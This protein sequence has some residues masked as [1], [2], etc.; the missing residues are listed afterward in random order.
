MNAIRTALFA[1]AVLATTLLTAQAEPQPGETFQEF[2]Y[3][4]RFIELD[5]ANT[6][7]NL[8]D[9]RKQSGLDRVLELRGVKNA[10]RAEVVVEYWGGHSGTSDQKFR[11]NGHDW[12]AIPQPEG[13]PKAPQSYYRTLLR[14]TAPIPV[15]DL[16]E[17]ANVFKFAAGPQI[18][19]NFN[20]GYFWVYAFTVRLYTK[21]DATKDHGGVIVLP[22]DGATIGD[23]PRLQAN[24]TNGALHAVGR[25]DFIAEYDDFNWEGDGVFRQWHYIHERGQLRRHVGTATAAPWAATWD[26]TWVP[27]Q[28]RP[29]RLVAR[30]MNTGGKVVVTPPV[31]ITLAR[32]DR[33]VRMY[34]TLDVPQVFGVRVKET[35]RCHFALPADLAGVRDARLVLSTWS[36]SHADALA[37]NGR[38]LVERV[39]VEHNYSFDSIPAPRDAL[40]PGENEFSIYS[41]TEH[42][43]AEVNWPGPVLLL[44]FGK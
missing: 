3:P 8:G 25:V 28:D 6:N 31:A 29:V 35:K 17:G 40:Q 42:H 20:W 39:G 36:A 16:V 1:S 24:V 5:P 27:D 11:A 7:P 15:G 38:R 41:A 44:E 30:V 21:P 12:I 4:W 32:P 33:S 2:V 9:M 23:H 26:T 14:A 22:A 19:A 34:R 43:A 13:T 18:F 10:V 37:L